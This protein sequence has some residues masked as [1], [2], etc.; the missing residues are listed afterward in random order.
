MN[1]RTLLRRTAIATPLVICAIAASCRGSSAPGPATPTPRGNLSVVDLRVH[2]IAAAGAAPRLA[3]QAL[4]E[5]DSPLDR[6]GPYEIEIRRQNAPHALGVCRG[7][8]LPRGRVA[9]CELWLVNEAALH[10]D[11]FE[12][13]LNRKI[14]DFGEWDVKPEDDQRKVLIRAIAEG[15][16]V[17]ALDS[18]E[19]APRIFRGPTEILFR[20]RVAGAHLA[21]LLVGDRPVR[22]VA[23]DPADSLLSGKGREPMTDSALLTLVARNSFGSFI[24]QT[25]AVFSID[26]QPPT[27]APPPAEPPVEA[28]LKVLDPG[29]YDV[30]EDEVIL[31]RI[32]ERLAGWEWV[33]AAAEFRAGGGAAPARPATAPEAASPPVREAPPPASPPGE[34]PGRSRGPS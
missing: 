12:A 3:I 31:E 18:F 8:A 33:R 13:A 19:V 21:W 11:V 2:Q 10:G 6:T 30:D 28:A 5:N 20:V 22:L 32:R 16:D 17:L 14:D 15:G 9:L 27:P 25:T 24:Y 26:Q 29:M 34:T 1:P 7:E 4:V 23:G